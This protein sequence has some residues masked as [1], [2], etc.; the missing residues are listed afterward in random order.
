MKILLT[1]LLSVSSLALGEVKCIKNK[2]ERVVKL[3]E[4]EKGCSVLSNG[5]VIY[6]AKV[7]K[8]FCKTK[9]ESHINKLKTKYGYACLG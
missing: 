9:Y 8:T 7:N 1:V 4:T 5:K 3:E 6:K 2:A